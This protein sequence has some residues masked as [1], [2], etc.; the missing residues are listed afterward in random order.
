MPSSNI[1]ELLLYFNLVVKLALKCIQISQNVKFR[2]LNHSHQLFSD[3][4]EYVIGPLLQLNRV[5]KIKMSIDVNTKEIQKT[6][7]N[8]CSSKNH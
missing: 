7:I 8:I 4:D 5:S 2:I 1:D 6:H 3:Y